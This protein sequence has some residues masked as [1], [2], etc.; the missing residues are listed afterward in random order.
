MAI[1]FLLFWVFFFTFSL[2]WAFFI[3]S[4]YR[5]KEHRERWLYLK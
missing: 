5:I 3:D 2:F 1:S 4:G